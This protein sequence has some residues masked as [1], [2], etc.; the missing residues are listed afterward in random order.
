MTIFTTAIRLA[1]QFCAVPIR[2]SVLTAALLC[3]TGIANLQQASAQTEVQARKNFTIAAQPLADAITAFGMQANIQISVSPSLVEGAQTE[4]VNGTMSIEEGLTALLSGTDF[5]W[6]SDENGIAI[7]QNLA[8]GPL[9]L[10]PLT[11]QGEKFNRSYLDTTTSVGVATA[12]DIDKYKL[13]ELSDIFNTMANVRHFPSSQGNKGMQIRGVSADGVSEP[14]NSAPTISVI[15]DGVAQSS[16]ALRRGSRG[17]WDMEQVEVLRGPQSTVHGPNAMAGAIVM[18]SSD[19]TYDWEAAAKG[20]YGTNERRD[21]A[22]MVNAPLVEDQLAIRLAAES[23][24]QFKDIEPANEDDR[25]LN[26]DDYRSLRGKVL[27]EPRRLDGLSVTLMANDVYDKPS[28]STVNGSDLFERKYDSGASGFSTAETREMNANNYSAEMVYDFD[29]SLSLT[30][31]TTFHD[32]ALSINTA[33]GNTAYVRSD[34]RDDENITQDLRLT[35]D[36]ANALTGTVGMYLARQDKESISSIFVGLGAG[37]G[38]TVDVKSEARNTIDTRAIYSDLRYDLGSGFSLLGGGRIQQ[39]TVANFIDRDVTSLAANTAG[40][41]ITFA[42]DMD[43]ERTDVAILPKLGV[44]Y[45]VTNSQVAGLTVS[46]GYRQ[47]FSQVADETNSTIREVE[48]EYVWTTELSWRD[49]SAKSLSWGANLFYN[50]YENQQVTISNNNVLS[51]FNAK[52]S[53]SYG[54]EIEGRATVWDGFSAFGALGLLKTQLGEINASSCASNSCEGND[55]PE[56]P[57][58]T[59]SLGGAW[60]SK[61]G[62]FAAA[63]VNYAGEYYSNSALTNNDT[64]RLNDFFLTNVRAGY[65]FE[66]VRLIAYVDNLFDKEYLTSSTNNRTQATIGDG[67]TVGLQLNAKF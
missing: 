31:V 65:Q 57:A 11:I 37:L 56:A 9:I 1:G 10:S 53:Y 8:T 50:S 7:V 28:S 4:G 61:S 17:T 3:T 23:R 64:Q 67:R 16:E 27:I 15:I 26:D 19:P 36:G 18:E 14:E 42:K 63:D 55:F 38:V 44:T 5:V 48:P 25:V 41:D 51:S 29:N 60:E 62:L 59:A 21:G 35:L 43:A 58:V 66:G 39:D 45:D 6:R 46:R 34:T 54:A 12:D 13:D 33:P 22:L 20:V 52:G 24:S 40:Q 49:K 47:G 32:A 30:S 2:V